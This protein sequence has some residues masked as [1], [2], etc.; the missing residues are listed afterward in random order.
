MIIVELSN[1]DLDATASLYSSEVQTQNPPGQLSQE[2]AKQQ[3]QKNFVH[4]RYYVF[5]S[6]SSEL[7]EVVNGIII[8]RTLDS[9]AKIF[10]LG[11]N[12]KG[13]GTGKSLLKM[14]GEFCLKN[15]IGAIITD[16]SSVDGRACS[17]YLH[18]GFSEIKR[19]QKEGFAEILMK[20]DPKRLKEL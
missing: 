20:A 6:K 13:K 7:E 8:F 1:K 15:H 2:E 5:I 17:F 9:R 14:L 19:K 3:L 16:V 10:F 12:P 4:K 11:T 18:C